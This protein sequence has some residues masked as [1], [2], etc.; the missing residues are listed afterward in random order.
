MIIVTRCPFECPDR[1][2]YPSSMEERMM[3]QQNEKRSKSERTKKRRESNS[4]RNQ[5][6]SSSNNAASSS[7]SSSSTATPSNRKQSIS[8]TYLEECSISEEPEEAHKPKRIKKV[9]EV[10]KETILL[11]SNMK[12]EVEQCPQVPNISICPPVQFPFINEPQHLLQLDE[13][14]EWEDHH[15]LTEEKPK[16][17][18]NIYE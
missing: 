15:G 3:L 14:F 17:N 2:G 9:Q 12:N 4:S 11:N 10:Q 7:S 18:N 1:R 8:N 6:N 16:V 5:R 13:Y